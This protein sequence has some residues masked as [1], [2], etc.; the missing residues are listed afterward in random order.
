MTHSNQAPR[1]ESGST[2]CVGHVERTHGPMK[3]TAKQIEP[4]NTYAGFFGTLSPEYGV[5]KTLSIYQQ[6]HACLVANMPGLSEG[7]AR[8]FLDSKYGR[9]MADSIFG[10][11]MTVEEAAAEIYGNRRGRACLAEVESFTDEKFYG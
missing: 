4:R 2:R 6:A 10:R 7:G 3:I 1:V 8:R 5:I 11:D 9:W